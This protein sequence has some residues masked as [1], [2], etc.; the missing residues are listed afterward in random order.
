M[1]PKFSAKRVN[2]QK[3]YEIAREGLEF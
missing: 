1:P 3:A 2:G